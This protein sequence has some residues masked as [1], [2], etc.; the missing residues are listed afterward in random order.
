MEITTF[1]YTKSIAGFHSEVEF[2]RAI[3]QRFVDKY[4][5]YVKDFQG[6]VGC[7][8]SEVAEEFICPDKDTIRRFVDDEQYKRFAAYAMTYYYERM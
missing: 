6:S 5:E 4:S 3:I 7:F 1:D 2:F 8:V